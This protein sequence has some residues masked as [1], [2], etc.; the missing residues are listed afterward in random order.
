[1]KQENEQ[2]MRLLHDKEALAS[3]VK[4]AKSLLILEIEKQDKLERSLT[5]ETRILYEKALKASQLTTEVDTLSYSFRSDSIS[6]DDGSAFD[7][8]PSMMQDSPLM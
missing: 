7:I 5:A 6:E 1:M 2:R 4:Y 3:A 8:S